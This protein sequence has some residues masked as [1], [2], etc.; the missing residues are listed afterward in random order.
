MS[1][2][3]VFK[4]K[5]KRKHDQEESVGGSRKKGKHT[6][7]SESNQSLTTFQVIQTLHRTLVNL[8]QR[9]KG[10]TSFSDQPPVASLDIFPRL[11]SLLEKRQSW[12]LT[13]LLRVP[14]GADGDL[15]ED[16]PLPRRWGDVNTINELFPL[17]K[18]GRP[19]GW[20]VSHLL[21]FV[22]C[23]MV[24]SNM[25]SCSY[26]AK[27]WEAEGLDQC[28]TQRNTQGG[29]EEILPREDTLL[30]PLYYL[31]RSVI[32]TDNTCLGNTCLVGTTENWNTLF[33]QLGDCKE[34][35]VATDLLQR[36][37][38][39]VVDAVAAPVSSER[40]RLGSALLFMVT[41]AFWDRHRGKVPHWASAMDE[42][43][44]TDKYLEVLPAFYDRFVGAP[45]RELPDFKD[46]RFDDLGTY[47]CTEENTCDVTHLK[48]MLVATELRTDKDGF[49]I[50]PSVL[51]KMWE[52]GN[53]AGTLLLHLRI[54]PSLAFLQQFCPDVWNVGQSTV[55]RIRKDNPEQAPSW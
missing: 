43:G 28:D 23:W 11:R 15:V 16:D 9:G 50:A 22:V 48:H 29:E 30:W 14:G 13:Q 52:E 34:K 33:K 36:S 21:I 40:R 41:D 42:K 51:G 24:V 3:V 2:C 20:T 10:W 7:P 39:P 5:K 45:C 6:S 32:T 1:L 37:S 31:I 26:H 25:D 17:D 19:Q 38:F 55:R 18:E 4:D 46:A 8:F 53:V 49:V 54:L 12:S 47:C 44:Q 27:H 35:Q